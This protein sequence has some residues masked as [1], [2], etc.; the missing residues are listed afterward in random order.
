MLLAAFIA[1]SLVVLAAIAL[2]LRELRRHRIERAF[3]W[4]AVILLALT[5][6][7]QALAHMTA[8]HQT[9]TA[10]ATRA[11]DQATSTRIKQAVIAAGAARVKGHFP[12]SG[13]LA[14]ALAESRYHLHALAN[15][16]PAHLQGDELALRSS[17]TELR[18]ITR[19]ADGTLVQL[20]ISASGQAQLVR[21][22]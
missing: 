5:G 14:L 6:G 15:V 19:A 10:A 13:P 7:Q 9:P 17:P 1:S 21:L 3:L 11:L 16:D 12:A 22:R 8:T 2:G 4:G 20:T 18:L